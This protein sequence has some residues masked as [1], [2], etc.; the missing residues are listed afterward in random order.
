MKWLIAFGVFLL[1]VLTPKCSADPFLNYNSSFIG[2]PRLDDPWNFPPPT[3]DLPEDPEPAVAPEPERSDGAEVDSKGRAYVIRVVRVQY[4]G[5][6]VWRC[7][8]Q[9]LDQPEPD[10]SQPYR[11]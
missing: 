5:K 7:W 8:Q 4:D 11:Y 9:Y 6:W 3:A 10:L 1:F 2:P